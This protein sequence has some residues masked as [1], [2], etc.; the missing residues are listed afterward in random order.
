[1]ALTR[2]DPVVSSVARFVLD[3]ALDDRMP[4]W[5]R[6]ARRCGV[7]RTTAVAKR[8]TLLLVRYR[9]QLTLPGRDGRNSQQ[10]A[11]DARLLAFRGGAA[12][13]EWLPEEEAFALLDARAAQ[14]TERQFAEDH[15]TKILSSLDSLMPT[16]EQH[17]EE[18]AA[19]LLESHR[20]VRGAFRDVRGASG[21]AR[22]GLRVAVQ[23]R[24]DV[25]GVYHYL[26]VPVLTGTTTNGE[27]R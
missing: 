13:A 15:I 16:L 14:N 27:A 20:R 11:E 10:L 17:G 6:P 2:T 3:A 23:G 9:F 26:P 5:Q 7:V 8:T 24:P 25:L 1:V 22:R 21:P 18:L 4:Q 19:R 12:N